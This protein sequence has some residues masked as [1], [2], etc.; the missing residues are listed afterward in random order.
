ML[1]TSSVYEKLMEKVFPL[2]I[3]GDKKVD[4]LTLEDVE[5]YSIKLEEF[6]ED[7]INSRRFL[8]FPKERF[9]FISKWGKLIENPGTGG[10]NDFIVFDTHT[11]EYTFGE[12]GELPLCDINLLNS[13]KY[14]NKNLRELVKL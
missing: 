11:G 7:T 4:C 6:I 14:I 10:D 2:D 13:S 5:D 9:K 3:G 8:E 1:D 12:Y